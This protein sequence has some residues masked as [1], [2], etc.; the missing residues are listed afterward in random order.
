MSIISYSEKNRNHSEEEIE[1]ILSILKTILDEQLANPELFKVQLNPGNKRN[2]LFL[3]VSG[4]STGTIQE[5]KNNILKLFKDLEVNNFCHSEIDSSYPSDKLYCF[6]KEIDLGNRI[7]IYK[8][9]LYDANVSSSSEVLLKFKFK[10]SSECT[11]FTMSYHFPT[12]G[13]E[14]W[15]Y[16]F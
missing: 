15:T 2:K 8:D 5:I 3:R 7:D 4:L 1:N 16:L 12:N 6:K 10:Y 9:I 11:V 13:K 14:E